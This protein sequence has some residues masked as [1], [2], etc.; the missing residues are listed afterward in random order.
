MGNKIE[1]QIHKTAQKLK[2]IMT[3]YFFPRHYCLDQTTKTLS[4][5]R[6]GKNK[7]D[8]TVNLVEKGNKV[9]DVDTNI[10]HH[11]VVNYMDF[12]KTECKNKIHTGGEFCVPLAVRLEGNQLMLLWTASSGERSIWAQAFRDTME[13]VDKSKS[14][15]TIPKLLVTTENEF[16]VTLYKCLVPALG[17]D[18]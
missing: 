13:P 4:I 17:P 5:F 14:N 1:G 8:L 2:P 12:F 15:P 18:G 16:I 3:D 10:T 6:V 9:I 7:P 11:K